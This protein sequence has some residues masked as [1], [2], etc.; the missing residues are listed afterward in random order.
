M[1]NYLQSLFTLFSKR[2]GS[3]VQRNKFLVFVI[4]TS[5]VCLIV[6]YYYVK[7]KL[8]EPNKIVECVQEDQRVLSNVDKNDFMHYARLANLLETRLNHIGNK[9][10]VNEERLQSIIRERNRLAQDKKTLFSP[11]EVLNLLVFDELEFLLIENEALKIVLTLYIYFCLY[12]RKW[13]P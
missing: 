6:Y 10:R 4:S 7:P 9:L 1:E 13:K 11:I 8:V 2:I 5:T 12:F 3:F